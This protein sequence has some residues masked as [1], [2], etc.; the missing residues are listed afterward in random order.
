M[1]TSHMIENLL[2]TMR[3][4]VVQNVMV[5]DTEIIFSIDIPGDKLIYVVCVTLQEKLHYQEH[6]IM[7]RAEQ[8]AKDALRNTIIDRI[9]QELV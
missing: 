4:K 6:E 5:M 2:S 3:C 1:L 8:V 9:K 7:R